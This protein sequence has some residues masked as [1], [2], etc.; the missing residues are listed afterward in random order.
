TFLEDRYLPGARESIAA[1]DLP[2]GDAWYAHNVKRM[3]TTTMTPK[4]IHELG[5]AEVA[6]LR[7]EME[8]VIAQTGF[9]GSFDSFLEFLRTDPQFFHAN[10][11]ELMRD[12][13]DI[14]K[15]IDAG[16]P[17]LFATLPR[18][19]YGVTEVPSYAEQSQTTAYYMPGAP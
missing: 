14:A 2:N 10:S 19:P 16:L 18:L 8:K 9:Q 17:S 6:T 7:A 5:L 15:R 1:T 3:P 12:Y 13:R 4:E 11:R